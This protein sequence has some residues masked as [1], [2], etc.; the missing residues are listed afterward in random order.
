MPAPAEEPAPAEPAA[1]ADAA[2]AD[3]PTPAEPPAAKPKAE[4]P[5]DKPEDPFAPPAVDPFSQNDSPL[6]TWTDISGRHH[7]VA[8]LVAVLDGDVVRLEKAD[9]GYVRVAFDRLSTLDQRVVRDRHQAVA[10]SW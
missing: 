8:R 1:P 7:V 10:M 3:E 4:E 2:P 6:R 9:G 5:E